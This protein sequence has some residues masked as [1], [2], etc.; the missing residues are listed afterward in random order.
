MLKYLFPNS[1]AEVQLANGRTA[2]C[3]IRFGLAEL[4]MLVGI[5][6]YDRSER[7][8]STTCHFVPRYM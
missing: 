6:Q 7:R 5:L 1:I 8:N 2:R 3:G 4:V